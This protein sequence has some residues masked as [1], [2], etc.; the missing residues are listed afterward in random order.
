[1]NVSKKAA[2]IVPY[3]AGEQAEGYIKLNTNEN[4]YPPSPRAAEALRGFDVDKL[5]LYPSPD[6]AG[7][8]AAIAKAEGVDADNIF[9]GNGSDEVLALAFA[10][11]FDADEPIEFADV[12]YS[13]YPV[14]ARLFDIPYNTIPLNDDF[15]LP[16]DKFNFYNG[17]VIANPNAPTSLSVPVDALRA[18]AER[19]RKA[20]IVDEAYIDFAD[21]TESAVR[22]TSEYDTLAVVKTFSKSYGL[23]GIRCGYMI[24]GRKIIDAMRAIKDSFNSY[25]VDRV[26]EAVCAAAVSD[27]EYLKDKI[28]KVKNTRSRVISEL[29]ARGVAVF[30]SDANFIFMEGDKSLYEKFKS[31][32]ILVRHFD[33]P[34][35]SDKLRVSVGTD[36]QMDEFLRVF[37]KIR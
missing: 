37:D 30:D 23:A 28:Q 11:L 15:S 31:Q 36:A 21:R 29:R 16:F 34:R 5:R 2:S 4:P 9:V 1:M 35:I 7:L 22:L 12:T 20:L 6:S 18:A 26:C 27:R 3:T 33:K 32:N 13:F 19:S 10:A 8:R 24:A 25:P 14:F 17:A